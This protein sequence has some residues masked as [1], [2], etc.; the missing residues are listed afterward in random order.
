MSFSGALSSSKIRSQNRISSAPISGSTHSDAE[1]KAKLNN[2]KKLVS[3]LR[4][5]GV[6][7]A[8]VA[9][10]AQLEISDFSDESTSSSDS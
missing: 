10:E 3:L 2:Y 1:S 6:D 9:L 8:Q 4:D 5:R 7:V